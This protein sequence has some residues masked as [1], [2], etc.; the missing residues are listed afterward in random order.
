MARLLITGVADYSDGF[1]EI[2]KSMTCNHCSQTVTSCV[3]ID[4]SWRQTL[5]KLNLKKRSSLLK[6]LSRNSGPYEPKL[7]YV[8]LQI[9]DKNNIFD[10][11]RIDTEITNAFLP[12]HFL[13]SSVKWPL[14]NP[15][16]F[17]LNKGDWS[18]CGKKLLDQVK[19]HEI[20]LSSLSFF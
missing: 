6:A 12:L 8:I 13:W 15:Q 5:L 11:P 19:P 14:K 10:S 2:Q 20:K 16:E 9:K 1:S 18:F 7:C 17:G 4:I 3:N